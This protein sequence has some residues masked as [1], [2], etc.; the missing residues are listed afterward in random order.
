MASQHFALWVWEGYGQEKSIW[1]LPLKKVIETVGVDEIARECVK[2]TKEIS[3]TTES[4]EINIEGMQRKD[5][6]EESIEG[7][8]VG[9]NIHMSG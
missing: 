7:Q 8:R 3:T 1:A 9:E 2:H 4:E 5:P 6:K